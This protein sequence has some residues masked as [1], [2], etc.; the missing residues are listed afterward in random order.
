MPVFGNTFHAIYDHAF[1][2]LGGTSFS[3]LPVHPIYCRICIVLPFLRKVSARA[4]IIDEAI[5]TSIAFQAGRTA[6]AD[7]K[8]Q[9]GI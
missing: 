3:M 7:P 9:P 8:T 5:Y 2:F 4:N 6:P 1:Q